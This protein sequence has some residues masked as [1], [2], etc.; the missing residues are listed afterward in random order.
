ME[1]ALVVRWLVLYAALFALGLP[2]VAQLLPRAD[3]RGAGLAVPAALVT[4]SVPAYWVGQVTWGPIALAAGVA[5][6]LLGS[7]LAGLDLTALLVSFTSPDGVVADMGRT[8]ASVTALVIAAIV[9]Y[10]L[11]IAS[12]LLL[13]L[14]A[15]AVVFVG[16][17]LTAPNGPLVRLVRWLL[18]ARDD[19]REVRE[20][21]A[22]DDL[23]SDDD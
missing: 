23:P 7:G 19:L 17:W 12:S 20:A 21:V 1:Y 18:A 6:L 16:S 4:L 2:L 14:V 15:A 13:G 8:R 11:V 22:P 9:G 5:T 10:A 3:G